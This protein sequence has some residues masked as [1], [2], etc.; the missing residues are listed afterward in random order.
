MENY[1]GSWGI[2]DCFITL[3]IQQL[4]FAVV[5]AFEIGFIFGRNC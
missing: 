4:L 2:T 5:V 3:T 1:H